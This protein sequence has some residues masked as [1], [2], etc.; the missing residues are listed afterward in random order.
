MLPGAASIRAFQS[1]R[2][3]QRVGHQSCTG[4]QVKNRKHS[5]TTNCRSSPRGGWVPT[6]VVGMF[7]DPGALGG[8]EREDS[9]EGQAT[10][11]CP[12]THTMSPRQSKAGQQSSPGH[13]CSSEPSL[14]STLPL[15]LTCVTLGQS[16]ALSEP[17]FHCTNENTKPYL[18]PA[19]RVARNERNEPVPCT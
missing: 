16:P 8:A 4:R 1:A 13:E 2:E 17:H 14:T 3:V 18:C 15:P 11:R 6:S 10:V 12:M 19:P 9:M 7:C 5:A